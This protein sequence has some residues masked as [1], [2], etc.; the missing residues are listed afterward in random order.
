MMPV[1]FGTEKDKLVLLRLFEDALQKDFQTRQLFRLTDGDDPKKQ[2][3]AIVPLHLLVGFF[4]QPERDTTRSDKMLD[5]Q[6]KRMEK[7]RDDLDE[8]WKQ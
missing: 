3:L 6:I 4:V 5:L 1:P 7:E 2:V 8:P